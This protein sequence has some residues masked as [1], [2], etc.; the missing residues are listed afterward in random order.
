MNNSEPRTPP[1]LLEWIFGDGRHGSFFAGFVV[2][3]S[4]FGIF[5]IAPKERALRERGDELNITRECVA[6][7]E[8]TS[9]EALQQCMIASSGVREAMEDEAKRRDALEGEDR[10]PP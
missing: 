7:G 5:S 6:A 1:T 3:T 2:A 9:L 8:A 4:F 10:P